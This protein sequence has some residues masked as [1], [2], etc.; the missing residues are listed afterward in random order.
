MERIVL[1][2]LI[3]WKNRLSVIREVIDDTKKTMEIDSEILETLEKYDEV[4]ELHTKY[5]KDFESYKG[6]K[7]ELSF[8]EINIVRSKN[9]IDS[10]TN[11]IK[12]M[13]INL[14]QLLE[15]QKDIGK[16][17]K[18]YDEMFL[19]KDSLSSKQGIPLYFMSNYLS[20]TEKITNELLS[21]A[22][23]DE[24][25]I[26][27]FDITPTEFAIPFFNRGIRL[28]DVK[29]ASQGELSFLS[30][31]LSFALSSQALNKYNIML[32]DEIDGPLDMSNR[33]KF[34]RVLENQ[35]D[36]IDAEQSFLI[37]HNAMF[38]SYP[39]DIIDLSFENDNTQYQLAN[40]IKIE[41]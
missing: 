38:S 39:V 13:T 4:K 9:D 35:I 16:M 10:L 19:V 20:N 11:K 12:E 32:L 14:S 29:Y 8:I 22:Y 17:N 27:A 3:E 21:I 26:D 1:N 37:T 33:E 15:L 30:I 25:Y 28:S 18:I 31:A 6:M 7:D 24:I 41:K 36:R 2:K 34:I 40:Y 5:T 23:D